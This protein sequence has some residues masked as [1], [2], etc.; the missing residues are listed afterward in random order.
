MLAGHG[1]HHYEISAYSQQGHQCE[2]NLNY[3]QFGDY[4]G[5][6]AG[7]HGKIS[8]PAQD[9]VIRTTRIRQPQAWMDR[10]D[11]L[12][13]RQQRTLDVQDLVFEFMLNALRLVGGFEKSL[14]TKHCG[15][16]AT[17]LD[18]G[19]GKAIDLELL[20]ADDGRL[21]PTGRGL[22]FHNDL[23]GLFLET[24]VST[25]ARVEPVVDLRPPLSS[26]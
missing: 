15:L 2:H 8:L 14:F 4:L 9:G 7:A 13:I 23:Q 6:G 16:P 24:D 11:Q 1:Y 25:L 21:V 18:E 17:L 26:R 3:W 20:T 10:S 22:R 5:I 12:S 19:I